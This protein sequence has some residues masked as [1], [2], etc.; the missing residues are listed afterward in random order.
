MPVPK[1]KEIYKREINVADAD[2]D[3]NDIYKGVKAKGEELEY[4]F[5]EKQHTSRPQKYGHEYEFKFNFYKHLDPLVMYEIVVEMKFTDVQILKIGHHGNG[6]ITV[7]ASL[8]YDYENKFGTNKMKSFF[9]KLYSN[10]AKNELKKKYVIPLDSDAS[11]IYEV[12]KQKLD[13]Y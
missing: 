4:T 5:F 7:K 2:F 9:Y 10:A 8:T 6:F 11:K 12:I 3:V 13:F 1:P